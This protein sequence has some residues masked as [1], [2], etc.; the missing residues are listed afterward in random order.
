MTTTG[1]NDSE[2]KMRRLFAS[3]RLTQLFCGVRL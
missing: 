3:L 2:S 1:E